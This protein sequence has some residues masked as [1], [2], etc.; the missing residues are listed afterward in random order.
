M[1]VLVHQTLRLILPLLC[2]FTRKSFSNVILL[3]SESVDHFC[4]SEWSFCVETNLCRFVFIVCLYLYN[5][6]RSNYQSEKGAYGISLIGLNPVIFLCL[7]Q[8]RI[9]ISNAICRG[10]FD[11]KLFKV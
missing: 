3:Q 11:I 4:D 5:R 10:L 2:P 8:V 7:S 6:W 1:G 9:W